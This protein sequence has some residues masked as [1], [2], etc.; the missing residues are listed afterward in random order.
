[1]YKRIWSIPEPVPVPFEKRRREQERK[2]AVLVYLG[3]ADFVEGDKG[4]GSEEGAERWTRAITPREVENGEQL[5]H[6]AQQTDE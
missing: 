4:N 5:R 1:M 6:E 3:R 2:R